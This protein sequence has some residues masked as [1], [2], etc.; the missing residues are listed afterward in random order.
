[1]KIDFGDDVFV[2]VYDNC[3]LWSSQFGYTI[4]DKIDFMDNLT[5]LDIGTGTGFP[6]IEIAER[7]GNKSVVYAMTFGVPH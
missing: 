1:M 2:S 3:P 6:A 7:M 5:V 4:L